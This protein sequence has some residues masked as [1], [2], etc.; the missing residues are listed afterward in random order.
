MGYWDTIW[1]EYYGGTYWQL[2]IIYNG[3]FTRDTATGKTGT[4][5]NDLTLPTITPPGVWHHLAFVYSDSLNI[6]AIYHDG[7]FSKQTTFSIDT[8]TSDRDAACTG[9]ASDEDDFNGRLDEIHLS[10]FTY[11]SSW[12]ATEYNNQN[13]PGLFYSI[14]SEQVN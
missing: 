9:F 7:H 1:D 12:I 14:G 13:N 6:K 5:N 4:R 11:N 2:T 8:L 10:T 3:W